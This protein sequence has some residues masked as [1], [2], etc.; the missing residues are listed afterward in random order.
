M[1]VYI[2][3]TKYKEEYK[4]LTKYSYKKNISIEYYENISE[5][6][7]NVNHGDTIIIYESLEN[8]DKTLKNIRPKKVYTH[9]EFLN[10]Y[11]FIKN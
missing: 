11:K 7:E 8:I 4:E 10:S 3:K 1:K 6:I 9:D 2:D 5:F